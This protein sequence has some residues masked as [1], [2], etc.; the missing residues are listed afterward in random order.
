MKKI[1]YFS[2]T[3]FI[4][5]FVF[6]VS[7]FAQAPRQILDLVKER[8]SGLSNQMVF[9]SGNYVEINK[10]VD[11]DL[12]IAGGEVG[13]F[14]R[15]K[16]DLLILGGK[17]LVDGEV[18]QDLRVVGGE[19]IVRGKIGRNATVVGGKVDV[20]KTAQIAGGLLAAGGEVSVDERAQVVGQRIIRSAPKERSFEREKMAKDLSRFLKGISALTAMMK[21]ISIL[22]VGFLLVKFFPKSLKRMM[23]ATEKKFG[24]KLLKG[25]ILAIVA[26]VIAIL[27]FVTIIGASLGV[28][29]LAIL[30]I[31][32]YAAK[33]AAMVFSGYFLLH[34]ASTKKFKIFDK[35][36]SLYASFL[37]GM[38]VFIILGMVPIFGWI[39][40]LL[41]ILACFGALYQE[42]LAA[43]RKVEK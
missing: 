10:E 29:T 37:V 23:E 3:S 26:P 38:L 6:T 31:A 17:V 30:A 40:K 39:I 8:T 43:Y 13:V 21:W 25:T 27:T 28:L 22:V 20:E 7:T 2:L 14:S 36:P 24:E 18:D 9:K 32:W 5:L 1:L 34:K 35:K 33:I 12:H 41:L 19:V 4:F 42:K 15:V 11:G 16:G